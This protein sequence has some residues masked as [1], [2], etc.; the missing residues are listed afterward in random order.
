MAEFPETLGLLNLVYIVLLVIGFIYALFLLLG[1]GIGELDLPDLDFD[2]GDVPSFDHGEVGLPSISP[3]SISSFITAFGAFGLISSQLFGASAGTSLFFAG[4]GGLAVGGIAQLIFI[5][6]FSPQ[7]SSLR[8]QQDIV[9]STAEVITPIPDGGV[10]Q[11]ALVSR[12]AR[13]TYSARTKSGSTFNQGDLVRV[14]E[15]VGSV[16]FVESR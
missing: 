15:L 1:Q 11:I 5:Y 3:M 7:T 4:G 13:V 10:G 6:V 12:G 2:A 16:T 9:G 14:V 8:R